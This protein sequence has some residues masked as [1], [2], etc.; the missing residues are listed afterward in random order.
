M[1]LFV[2]SQNIVVLTSNPGGGGAAAESMLIGGLAAGDIIVGVF[3]E[4]KGA[5][6]LPLLSYDTLI[7]GA[8][9]CRWVGAPGVGAVVKVTVKR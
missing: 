6:D 8:L 2:G 4:I 3:Q 7:D 1:G 9:T 5:A